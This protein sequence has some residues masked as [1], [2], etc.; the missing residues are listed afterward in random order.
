MEETGARRSP[1][2]PRWPERSSILD[3]LVSSRRWSEIKSKLTCSLFEIFSSSEIESVKG[4]DD[5]SSLSEVCLALIRQADAVGVGV[6]VDGAGARIVVDI[7]TE[8][9]TK[10][11]NANRPHKMY[12][13]DNQ[14]PPPAEDNQKR[15]G[16][17]K[18]LADCAF[19]LAM[20][21]YVLLYFIYSA[22]VGREG[23]RRLMMGLH[24][25]TISI[26][27][28]SIIC[29]C[30]RLSVRSLKIVRLVMVGLLSVSGCVV[31]VLIQ[32]TL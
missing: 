30:I 10:G 31:F 11:S 6:G 7:P 32:L 25:W 13:E 22:V 18:A 17:M 27:L 15:E 5:H 19:L 21:C 12:S 23:D 20:S 16:A 8:K 26:I 14:T 9:S 24:V 3:D 4:T 2:L 28:L 1:P 29:L